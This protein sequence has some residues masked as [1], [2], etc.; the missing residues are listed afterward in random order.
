LEFEHAIFT[1]VFCVLVGLIYEQYTKRNPVWIMWFA[2]LIPDADFVVQTVWE[3]IFPMKFSPIIHGDFHNIFFLICSALF[4]GWYIWKHTEIRFDDAALCIS[5][6]FIAHLAED[7]LVNG[8]RYHF[9]APFSNRG[10]YQGFIIHPTN[11]L[12]FAHNV[13]GSTNI[14]AI[15]VL[16]LILAIMIRSNIQGYDWLKKYNFIPFIL[17]AIQPALQSI[18]KGV[19]AMKTSMIY[20]WLNTEIE[21]YQDR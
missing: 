2:M 5:L 9:Y 8:T 16:L 12:I 7:A 19:N 6:G 3:A 21:L 17:K 4:A 1:A 13:I 20:G 18:E 10:W 14:L 11:D 15:G